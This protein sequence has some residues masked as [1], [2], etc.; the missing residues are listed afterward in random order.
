[1]LKEVEQQSFRARR[2]LVNLV[3]AEYDCVLLARLRDAGQDA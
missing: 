1:M 3:Q 2:G